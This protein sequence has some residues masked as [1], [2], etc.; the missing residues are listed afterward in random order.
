MKGM[1]KA[2]LFKFTH[3]YSLWI[4]IGVL[5]IFCGISTITGTYSSAENALINISKDSMVLILA[6]AVY[7]SII[8][9]EDFSNGLLRHFVSNGYKRTH[10]VLAKVVHYIVGCSILLLAYQVISVSF[11]ALIQGVETSFLTVIRTT[12]FTSL[13]LLPLYLGVLGLFF[14]LAVLIKKGVIVVGVSVATSILL[15]VFT[16]KL[17]SDTSSILK[18][19]PIIQI[20]EVANG[21]VTRFYFISILLSMIV[22]VVCVLGSVIKFNHDEL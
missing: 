12:I 18:Y 16:N 10:I 3:S 13:Q 15:V 17:Y 7:G 9:T 20:S 14:L 22:L 8:L 2:E 5:V 11:A 19:S 1:L 21:T 6:S 4:I